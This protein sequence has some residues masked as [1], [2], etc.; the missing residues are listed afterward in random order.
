[1]WVWEWSQSCVLTFHVHDR[2]ECWYSSQRPQSN[3]LDMK[4]R[5]DDFYYVFLVN[6]FLV[7]KFIFGQ[8]CLWKQQSGIF[9]VHRRGC[10]CMKKTG[11]RTATCSYYVVDNIT[12]DTAW[13]LFL[14]M[15]YF[16]LIVIKHILSI[17]VCIATMIE[18]DTTIDCLKLV[19]LVWTLLKWM[20]PR[21]LWGGLFKGHCV[22]PSEDGFN[23]CTYLDNE[24][25][26]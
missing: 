17:V 3:I 14:K 9:K 15:G 20:W 1:M 22:T 21:G 23:I 4:S 10:W 25:S 11:A 18:L 8:I 19:A 12:H 5:S 16:Q 2:D 7:R 24:T 6:G 13:A 26:I